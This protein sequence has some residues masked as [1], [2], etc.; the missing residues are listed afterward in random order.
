MGSYWIWWIIA[1]IHIL[2]IFDSNPLIQTIH[3]RTPQSPVQCD[4]SGCTLQN[5]YGAWGDRKD[6]NALN[7]TYPT[8]EEEFRLAVS[9]AVQNNLKVKVVTKF[10]H[11]IPKLACPEG[12]NNSLLISTEKYDSGIQIDAANLA[13]TADSGVGLRALIDAVESAGFSLVAAP[14]WEGVS[15]GGLISTGAHGSSW[16]G[17]GGAVHDHVLG[18]SIIVPASESEGYA[19]ILRLEAQDPLF[20]AARVSLGVLC[21]IS[22]VKLSLE[23]R[24]KRSITYNFTDDAHIEDVYTDH[25]KQYEFADITWYP[26]KNTSVYRYDSRVP[27]NASGDGVYDFIGFQ[28]NS[29]LISKSVRAAEKLLENAKNVKGKCLTA[30][31]TLGFK[32]LMGNGLKNNALLFTGYPVVGYQ[33][34]MQTSGS[35]LYS[36]KF[37]TACAWDPRIKGLFFYESTA[38]FPASKFGDFIQD[39][40]K[41]RDLNPENFCGID[42]YNGILIRFIK[43]SDAYLGQS[44]D[45]VVIDFNYYR[46]NDASAPRLNQDVWEEVEQ[47]AF[48]KYGAKPH[49]A[50]NRKLAFL[51]VQKKYPKFDQFIAAKQ[52]LDPQSVFSSTWSE[53]I[54]YGN[55][56][57]KFDGCALEGLCICSEDKHCSPQMGYYCKEGL[58]YKE[59]RVC[60]Y[61]SSSTTIT[62]IV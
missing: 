15:I 27:L 9:Q 7:I 26:S 56:S 29:I 62:S 32:K 38:I 45:S 43:A 59:A 19:K 51:G 55:E 6:C 17:K 21:A 34:K 13:V 36:T 1:V 4:Q 8:T 31:T 52:Q 20:N 11:T 23:P 33:G 49:W 41:L 16:W 42:N 60:R 50:K 58:I 28:A 39:V 37:D 22:K 40:R 2:P 5:S 3:A 48:F 12:K 14:Y 57:E 47:L 35:C 24:F 10:S 54:L 18:L 44:E 25:A 46:A 61:S 53:E 30:A